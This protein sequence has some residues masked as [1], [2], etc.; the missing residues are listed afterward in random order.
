MAPQ[1][2]VQVGEITSITDLP[3]VLFA[4]M[5]VLESRDL[6]MQ[7]QNTTLKRHRN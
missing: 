6:A 7:S 3:L 1:K 5:N 2:T 4:G